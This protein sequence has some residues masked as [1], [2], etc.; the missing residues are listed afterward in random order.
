MSE[1]EFYTVVWKC[2]TIGFCTFLLSL[3]SC[4]MHRNAQIKEI[5]LSGH[6]PIEAACAFALDHAETQCAITAAKK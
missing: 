5:V 6:S 3:G 4:M 1:N 2:I